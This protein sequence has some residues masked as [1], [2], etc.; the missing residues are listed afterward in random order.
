MEAF[1]QL[2]V[3][4]GISDVHLRINA[5][6]MVRK[7]GI[8]MKTKLAP[9][10]AEDMNQ[11][12]EKIVPQEVR[13]KIST[14]YDVDFSIEMPGVSRFRANILHDLGKI[15]MVLRVVPFEVPSIEALSLPPVLKNFTGLNNGLILVT[16]PTGSGK[17]TTLASILDYLNQKYQKHIISLEDPIEFIHTNK[18]CIFTQRQLGIDTDSFPNGLKYALRQDP[19]II[20]IGEMRDRETISSALKAAETGHLVFSTLHTTDAVQTINRII[21]AF[22]PH[23]REPIRLQIAATLQGTIAQ[24]LVKRADNKGR[25]PATELLVVTPAVR[26]YIARDEIEK[27][28]ELVKAGDY[29]GMMSMNIS[30]LRLVQTGLITQETALQSSDTPT[31]MEILLKGAYHGVN[32]S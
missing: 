1:L 18:K 10:T 4:Q 26:D 28:Y 5:P 12:I 11:V 21:N 19:D 30:L 29:N 16:G 2:S 20:L 27:I 3:S 15:G 32:N 7:D 8:M 31:E 22:E 23:E 25:I 13:A 6:P 14:N 24:K 9:L 17:S